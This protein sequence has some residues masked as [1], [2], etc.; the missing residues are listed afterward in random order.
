ME[1]VGFA[2]PNLAETGGFPA[3]LRSWDC[4]SPYVRVW[5]LILPYHKCC[6][7]LHLRQPFW[8]RR[9][10]SNLR[11]LAGYLFSRQAPSTTRPRLQVFGGFETL[12]CQGF[13]G[14][15]VPLPVTFDVMTPVR[16]WRNFGTPPTNLQLAAVA[17]AL[18]GP[19]F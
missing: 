5:L 15:A 11:S 18:I 9:E 19:T 13:G 7:R 14:Q 12:L 8:R 4:R 17:A 3:S 1:G 16:L 6:Q 2:R 10:D